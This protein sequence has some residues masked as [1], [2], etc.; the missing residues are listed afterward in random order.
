MQKRL[1]G[2]GSKI[3]VLCLVLFAISEQMML[4]GIKVADFS[5]MRLGT[6]GETW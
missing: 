1:N 6:W 3:V 4:T 5:L 2:T